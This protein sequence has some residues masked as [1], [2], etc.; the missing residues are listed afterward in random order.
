MSL[1]PL[2]KVERLITVDDAFRQE[3]LHQENLQLYVR[4]V[5]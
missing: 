3:I 4:L 1:P 2:I 5:I